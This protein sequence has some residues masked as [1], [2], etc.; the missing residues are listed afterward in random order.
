MARG[1]VIVESRPSS[2]A[3]V[4]EYNHWYTNVHLPEVCAVPGFV[5]ASRYAPV[6]G[7][8]PYVA[9]YEL[10]CD[11][12]AGS[13]TA[14]GDAVGQGSIHMSDVLSMDPAPTVRILELTASHTPAAA[15]R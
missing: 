8:G 12:L 13:M 4:D 9:I 1:I 6:D 7:E 11:D 14:L 5:G 2:P 3:R 10:D 15:G